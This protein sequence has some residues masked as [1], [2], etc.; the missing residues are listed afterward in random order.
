ME[1]KITHG[2]CRDYLPK[3]KD[4]SI[5]CIIT[6][7]P[8]SGLVNKSKANGGRF[9]KDINHIEFDDMSERAFLLFM[10]PIFREMYRIAKMGSHLYCFT[11]WK[12]LRNMMDTLEL[13]GWKVVNVVCWDKGH[14]GTGAGYRSQTE[15][16]LVFSKGLS[17][18]FN[19]KNVGNVI[20]A[21][22]Q[23]KLHPHQKPSELIDIFVRN[24]TQEGDVVLDPFIGCGTTAVVSKA[25]GREYIGYELSENYV[26]IAENQLSQKSLKRS[27]LTG[28]PGGREK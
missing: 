8:Y 1:S 6:D 12:Q 28:N 2:D 25:L 17:K 27:L 16:I 11:D 19:L 3:L 21:K 24:S 14:F 20:K 23:N 18:T 26:K 22:R 5:D 15:Y 4:E 13:T 10:K 9:T 7:P